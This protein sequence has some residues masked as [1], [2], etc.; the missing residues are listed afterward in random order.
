[1]SLS[2]VPLA[3][4]GKGLTIEMFCWRK[5]SQNCFIQKFLQHFPAGSFQHGGKYLDNWKQNPH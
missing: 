4:T 5:I 3:K 2:I 1:M